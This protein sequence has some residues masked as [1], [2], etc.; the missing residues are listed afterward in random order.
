L[1]MPKPGRMTMPS[2][3]TAPFTE[4]LNDY[5]ERLRS[6][7]ARGKECVGY[8]CT[9]TPVDAIHAAGFL[10]IRIM[11]DKGPVEKAYSLAPDFICPYMKRSL[12]KALAGEYD[13]LSGIIQGYTCDKVEIDV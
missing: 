4:T 8:F 3:D 12:E 10:P 13:F 2:Y 5:P 1:K 9:Y 6:L 7:T 11:G